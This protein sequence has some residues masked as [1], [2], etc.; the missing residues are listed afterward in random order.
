MNSNFYD[1]DYYERGLVTGKSFYQDYTWLP[2]KTIPFAMA[3]IDFLEIK[4]N[5]TI[6]DFGCAKGYL[7]KAFRSLHRE[8]WGV[9]I[10]DYALQNVP[11]D[12][13]AFCHPAEKLCPINFDFCIAKDVF[14]HIPVPDLEKILLTLKIRKKLFAII[15]LGKEDCYYATVNNLDK[16]HIICKD[17]EWWKEFFKSLH[18][19]CSHFSFRIEGLKDNYIQIPNA[20]GFFT[21]E[22]K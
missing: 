10:S 18:W 19:E 7:V 22:K 15:P 20:Y 5:H 14:E 3:M 16:S 8:A 6:L 4:R 12:I 1:A 9:D 2:E 17:E 13:K 21:L 11:D